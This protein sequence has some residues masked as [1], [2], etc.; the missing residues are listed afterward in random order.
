MIVL[1]Q[2]ELQFFNDCDNLL[3]SSQD[4]I[5][6]WSAENMTLEGY[7]TQYNEW[8]AINVGA[9]Q[10]IMLLNEAI[11]QLTIFYAKEKKKTL[12]NLGTNISNVINLWFENDYD[13]E[14]VTYVERKKE[15]HRLIDKVR[16]GSLLLVTG[17]A[18]QQTITLLIGVALTRAV[19]GTF[20]FFDEAFSNFGENEIKNVPDILSSI[21]DLQI[22]YV[23][24]KYKLLEGD[25]VVTYIADRDNESSFITIEDPSNILSEVI[26]ELNDRI[27]I[28]SR[29]IDTLKKFGVDYMTLPNYQQYMEVDTNGA[30]TTDSDITDSKI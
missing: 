16:G 22:F 2:E 27:S 9:T 13:L 11:K 6:R 15:Y 18:C 5:T 8:L 1:T 20:V 19:G 24:H 26:E 23:E 30:N 25:D 21:D 4:V 3:A 28:Q 10:D 7:E 14:F 29:D 17:G 12:T